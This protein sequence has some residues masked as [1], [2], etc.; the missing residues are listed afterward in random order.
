MTWFCMLLFP[1]DA[2][3]STNNKTNYNQINNYGFIG[4]DLIETSLKMNGTQIKRID[5]IIHELY[6]LGERNRM[7]GNHLDQQH[8]LNTKLIRI[9]MRGKLRGWKQINKWFSFNS[10]MLKCLYIEISHKYQRARE[11]EKKIARQQQSKQAMLHTH[12]SGSMNKIQINRWL[13]VIYPMTLATR[14]KHSSI[15]MMIRLN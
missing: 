12:S 15:A 10:N 3:K 8:T 5:T 4:N 9:K 6:S 7:G 1:R 14:F 11:E 13:M 2:K